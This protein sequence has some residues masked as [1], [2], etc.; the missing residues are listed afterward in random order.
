MTD[1]QELKDAVEIANNWFA[2]LERQKQN[3]DVLQKAA[4]LARKGDKEGAMKLKK[5]VDT[6]PKIYDGATLLPAVKK[7]VEAAEELIAIKEKLEPLIEILYNQCERNGSS[8]GSMCNVSRQ[9]IH[10]LK[11]ANTIKEIA[12]E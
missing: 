6:Q 11:A 12:D 5:Q 3:T 4:S 8:D 1:I 9:A 10:E 2:Y 7:F